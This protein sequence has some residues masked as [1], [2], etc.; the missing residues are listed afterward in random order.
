M[1]ARLTLKF[2]WLHA[3][4]DNRGVSIISSPSSAD[5]PDPLDSPAG[6]LSFRHPVV[7]GVLVLGLLLSLVAWWAL[8]R[9]QAQ[10]ADRRFEMQVQVR[11]QHL[12]RHVDHLQRLARSFQGLFLAS[13][14]V[15]AQEFAAHFDV[16]QIVRGLPEVL[17][18]RY[19]NCSAAAAC[20]GPVFLSTN[21]LGTAGRD[22]PAG[23]GDAA[24]AAAVDADS[25]DRNRT[26][27]HAPLHLADGRVVL[28]ISAPVYL[29][30]EGD[31]GSVES[32]RE[33]QAGTC[34]CWSM[35]R[36]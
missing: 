20:A 23:P 2:Q 17:S 13:R 21:G 19:E 4:A 10:E 6:E 3:C 32:R 35:R 33:H 16:L 24:D 8:A 34:G 11:Q 22:L 28:Q 36:G 7:A 29:G 12:V 25:R 18:V 27:M 15:S 30:G 14:E 5:S 9:H 1:P 26:V 31:P